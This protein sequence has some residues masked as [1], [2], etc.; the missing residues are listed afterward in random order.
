MPAREERHVALVVEEQI[1]HNPVTAGEI[2]VPLVELP[3]IRVDGHRT[4]AIH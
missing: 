1:E 4:S 2:H 3:Q